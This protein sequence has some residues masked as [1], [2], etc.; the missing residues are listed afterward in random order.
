MQKAVAG[1]S[2]SSPCAIINVEPISDGKPT[3]VALPLSAQRD[4]YDV[5]G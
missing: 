1:Y 3:T 4:G 5:A 2:S